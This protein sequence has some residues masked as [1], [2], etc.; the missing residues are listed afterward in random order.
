MKSNYSFMADRDGG[1]YARCTT[2]NE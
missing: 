2:G 1:M